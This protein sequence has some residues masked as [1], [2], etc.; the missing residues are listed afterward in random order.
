MRFVE[1]LL[2]VR[3]PADLSLDYQQN[4]EEGKGKEKSTQREKFTTHNIPSPPLGLIHVWLL[5]Q[6]VGNYVVSREPSDSYLRSLQGCKR[7]ATE[8]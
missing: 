4:L 1:R 5:V 8:E 3:P 7:L 6:K 2:K